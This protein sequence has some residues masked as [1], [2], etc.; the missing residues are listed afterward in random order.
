[1][2]NF[3]KHLEETQKT[4]EFRIKLADIDPAEKGDMLKNALDAYGLQSISEAKR[5]PI[6]ET[7]IDFPSKKNCQIYL[8]DAVLTYPVNDQQLR[9][10]ISERCCIAAADVVVVPKNHP[11]EIWRWNVDGQSEL[12]EFKKGEAVLDKPLE[13][14]DD[15]GQ[16]ENYAKAGTL[17][18]ELSGVK[19]EIEGGEEAKAQTLNDIPTGDKS[20]IGSTQNKIPSP[21]KGN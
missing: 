2:K 5:L 6:K 12:R 4:Y 15:Q 21:V 14:T 3:I 9:G 10:I 16:G 18:K 7:D 1:M 13:E 11:E 17:L 19:F 20:P 8:M